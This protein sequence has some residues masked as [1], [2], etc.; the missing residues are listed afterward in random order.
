MIRDCDVLDR[1]LSGF[2]NSGTATVYD[3]AQN[4]AKRSLDAKK[5]IGLTDT[6]RLR[7]TDSLASA[8]TVADLLGRQKVRRRANTFQKFSEDTSWSWFNE[9]DNLVG[10]TPREAIEYFSKQ[11]PTYS[12]D[13]GNFEVGHQG[14]AFQL[15]A[16]TDE[17]ITR[18]IFDVILEVLQ[19]GQKTKQAP[20][21]IDE[22]LEQAGIKPRKGY[23]EMVYRTNLLESYRGGAWKEFQAP[24]L[25]TWFPVW[26]YL[27]IKDHRQREKHQK[28]T[29]LYFD[30]D[31][32]FFQVRGEDASD[33]CNCRCDFNPVGRYDWK[34]LQK[35]GVKTTS[36]AD[37]PGILAM[38]A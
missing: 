3:L 20:K 21:K 26:H 34:K 18:K 10:M 32:P 6:E 24:D 7:L 36:L 28:L 19:T 27:G 35:S 30:R 9:S 25:A 12:I 38:T 31:V 16:T 29:G 1:L 11:M 5:P 23:G 8:N 4:V 15:A 37:L 33:V 2:Q 14:R 17:T 22:I 13:A